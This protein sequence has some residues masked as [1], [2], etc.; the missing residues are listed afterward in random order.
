[1]ICPRPSLESVW[2][3]YGSLDS[4]QVYQIFVMAF[5]VIFGAF[6]MGDVQKTKLMQLITTII[7]HTSFG[8]MI[9]LAI[10]GIIQHQG[11]S[12]KQVLAYEDPAEISTFLGVCIY[13]FMCHHRFICSKIHP[14]KYD[15]HH[16]CSIPGLVAPIANKKKV[17]KVL[18]G[19]FLV[20]NDLRIRTTYSFSIH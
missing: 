9:V 1:M 4:Y 19:A 7:R 2:V 6:A 14:S 18:L 3:C 20:I 15:S 11:R 16:I 10:I 13:S 8:L 17:R 5:A 12:L